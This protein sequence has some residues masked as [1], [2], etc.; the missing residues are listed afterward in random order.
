MVRFLLVKSHKIY[1]ISGNLL[2]SVKSLEIGEIRVNSKSV[3]PFWGVGDPLIMSC[4]AVNNKCLE[5]PAKLDKIK[6][7]S[8]FGVYTFISMAVIDV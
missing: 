7:I 6:I 4:F 1:G 3:H 5:T 8:K 2:K